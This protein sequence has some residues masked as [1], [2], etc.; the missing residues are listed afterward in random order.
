MLQHIHKILFNQLWKGFAPCIPNLAAILLKKQP[1]LD[2]F[3]II[4]LPSEVSGIPVLRKI[5]GYI[6]YTQSGYDYLPDKIN[7]F[8]WL[9]PANNKQAK[10][11][12]AMPQIICA[13]FRLELLS[14]EAQKILK[15]YTSQI[16]PFDF[17]KFNE[18]CSLAKLGQE[19][20]VTATTDMILEYIHNLPWQLPTAEDYHKINAEN[21]LIAWVL[22]FGRKIN[23]FGIGV[24]LL[25][26]F[27]NL[28]EYNDY[29]KQ[30]KLVELNDSS[31]EIKGS[32]HLGIEQSSSIGRP[33]KVKL[34]DG[35]VTANDSFIEF[36]WRH[37]QKVN[38]IMWSDYYTDFLAQNATN[39]VESL[40]TKVA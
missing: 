20:Y 24:H 17:E 4:D 21:Q 13:D 37:P 18:I 9:A 5:F 28:K 8:I 16:K 2:H 23:H 34:A 26:E 1:T 30:N 10:A 39:V 22:L 29:L 36:V 14:E 27:P 33:I 35:V 32:K 6:G 40:F 38:P 19:Q 11:V 12:E 7:D 25:D 15:K 3:A 31:A